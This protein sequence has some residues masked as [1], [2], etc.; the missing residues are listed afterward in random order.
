MCIILNHLVKKLTQDEKMRFI[1]GNELKLT[2]FELLSYFTVKNA[3]FLK[4]SEE[5]QS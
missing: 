4:C 5:A 2:R 1:K 3:R